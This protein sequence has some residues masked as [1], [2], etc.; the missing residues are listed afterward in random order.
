MDWRSSIETIFQS[1]H[2]VD[3]LTNYSTDIF[4]TLSLNHPGVLA[5]GSQ[6][7]FFVGFL[8]VVPLMSHMGRRKQFLVSVAASTAAMLLFSLAAYVKVS[9]KNLI[10]YTHTYSII[11]T[12]TL[13]ELAKRNIFLFRLSF[14]VNLRVFFRIYFSPFHLQTFPSSASTVTALD[15]ILGSS[16]FFYCLSFGAGFFA[17]PSA[18]MGELYPPGEKSVCTAITLAVR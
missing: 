11:W 7:M 10:T 5:A 2:G 9:A 14:N 6:S 8:I 13:C 15:W 17:V 16:I 4:I 12:W 3:T 18:L 1:I